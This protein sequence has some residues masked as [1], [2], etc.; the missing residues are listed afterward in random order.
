MMDYLSSCLDHQIEYN[1][2]QLGLGHLPLIKEA[3]NF[4]MENDE[5]VSRTED[6][7]FY[8]KKHHIAIQ[9]WSPFVVGFFK[10]SLFDE[11]RFPEMNE[12]MKVIA[13]K[14]QRSKC[15]VATAFLLM[16]DKDLRVITGS[17]DPLHV[18]ECLD[19][20]NLSLTKEEWY[21]LYAKAGNMLP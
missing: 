19:G 15:A 5:G 13:D 11:A 18:Q 1:Q 10:G 4:N 14:Y 17:M 8:M 12:A 16:L 3:I 2:V 21:Y 20:E 7:F 9:A 6:T